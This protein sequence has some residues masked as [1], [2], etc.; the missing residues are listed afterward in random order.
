LT[1]VEKYSMR[2][3]NKYENKNNKIEI[4]KNKK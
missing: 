1:D 2:E 4:K 3:T